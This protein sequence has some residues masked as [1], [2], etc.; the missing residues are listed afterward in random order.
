MPSVALQGVSVLALRGG[1]CLGLDGWEPI[2]LGIDRSLI[3][4]FTKR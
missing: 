1:G 4:V 3:A 2:R